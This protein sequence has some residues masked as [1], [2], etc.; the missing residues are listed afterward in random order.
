MAKRIIAK[1]TT[2]EGKEIIIDPEKA[3]K[4][5]KFIND[6]IEIEGC[7]YEI[8]VRLGWNHY[9]DF[10]GIPVPRMTLRVIHEDRK[11]EFYENGKLEIYEI[12]S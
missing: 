9:S 10:Y 12:D 11:T 7:L 2:V 5:T 4:D 6:V 1:Y 3:S 8:D